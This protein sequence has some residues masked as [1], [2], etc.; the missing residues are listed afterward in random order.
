M[1]SLS[2]VQWLIEGALSVKKD[3]LWLDIVGSP[4]SA[5][6]SDMSGGAPMP[7]GMSLREKMVVGP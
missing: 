2:L 4:C 3:K 1:C 6:R 7:F 5:F